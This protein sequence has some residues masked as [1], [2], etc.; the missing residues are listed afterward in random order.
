MKVLRIKVEVFFSEIGLQTEI[1]EMDW[2]TL[3]SFGRSRN[4]YLINPIRNAPVRPT[5]AFLETFFTV[6]GPPFGG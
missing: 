3:G 1:R 4:A 6:D 5:Q 2:A